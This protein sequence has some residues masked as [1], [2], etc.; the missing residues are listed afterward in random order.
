M[1]GGEG[2]FAFD[3]ILPGRYRIQVDLDGFAPHGRTVQAG[4]DLRV[5]VQ[6]TP[7]PFT[8]TVAV[9]AG[10]PF[11]AVDAST[12]TGRGCRSR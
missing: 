9:E 11:R 7:A 12:G 6:L 8:E 10:S 1:T 2:Q 3:D 5:D 4:R